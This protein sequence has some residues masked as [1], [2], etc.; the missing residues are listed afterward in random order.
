MPLPGGGTMKMRMPVFG[1]KPA[2][3]EACGALKDFVMEAYQD[4][5]DAET[6]AGGPDWFDK[7]DFQIEAKAENA[8]ARQQMRLM[9]QSLL[10]ERFKLKLHR[11]SRERK[12]Y[13]LTVE[14][15]G[16]KF[17]QSKDDA[18]NPITQRP[19]LPLKVTADELKKG[20]PGLLMPNIS[21]ADRTEELRGKAVTLASLAASLRTYVGRK[22][23]DKTGL[24]GF[25]DFEL[26]F[27]SDRLAN[28]LSPAS[29]GIAGPGPTGS[30]AGSSPIQPPAEAGG[31]S[32]FGAL[33]KQLGLKLEEN[34][35]SQ[36]Y[37]VI[38]S[39]EM[40]SEN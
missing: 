5:R 18:G 31:P 14:K 22:V 4:E 38:D 1:F 36:D 26:R 28:L 39:A 29:S 6:I 12:V 15:N 19:P 24:V 17:R 25:Y 2:R 30:S 10:E 23:I 3:Y 21:F 40:P 37:I 32:I 13:W 27:T 16:P 35:V 34:K 7:T 33:Q 11:E 9:L 8:V 20:V